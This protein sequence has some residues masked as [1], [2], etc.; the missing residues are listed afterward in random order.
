MTLEE[1]KR[2]DKAFLMPTDVAPVLDCNPHSVRVAAKERPEFLGFPVCVI[3]NRVKIPRLPFIQFV[4][5][6][7]TC[8]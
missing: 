6:G 7:V 3:G 1:M 4:E 5:R 8:E 2:S